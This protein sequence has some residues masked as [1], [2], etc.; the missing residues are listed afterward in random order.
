MP[1]TYRRLAPGAVQ[2]THSRESYGREKRGEFVGEGAQFLDRVQTR[3]EQ[4]QVVLWE[5][6][7]LGGRGKPPHVVHV[8]PH[9]HSGG[10]IKQSNVLRRHQC[11]F[12]S[13]LM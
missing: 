7:P 5:P 13:D 10:H 3:S 11:A 12:V 4:N 6:S 1:P 9:I 8:A 2:T